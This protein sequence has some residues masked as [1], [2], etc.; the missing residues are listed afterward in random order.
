MLLVSQVSGQ[1]HLKDLGLTF[2]RKG[3]RRLA[4][5]V[6][7]QASKDLQHALQKQWVRKEVTTAQPKPTGTTTVVQQQVDLEPLLQEL[8]S[9]HS[10]LKKLLD[11]PPVIVEQVTGHPAQRVVQDTEQPTVKKE[12]TD[13]TI[14][15]QLLKQQ[16]KEFKQ[17]NIT[18][19]KGDGGKLDK[20]KIKN[21]R[22]K[23]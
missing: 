2:Y 10:V 1:L 22:S 3:D 21:L 6:E 20:T 7:A 13:P 18:A 5:D 16:A 12:T 19:S 4:P 11:K 14:A 9:I 23:K 17:S 15:A 8:Q